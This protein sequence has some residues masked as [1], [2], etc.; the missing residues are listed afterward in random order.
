M[1]TDLK[2]SLGIGYFSSEYFA[3]SYAEVSWDQVEAYR[4]RD[5]SAVFLSEKERLIIE[6]KVIAYFSILFAAFARFS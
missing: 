5:T 4:S 1:F 2:R 6:E 3:T